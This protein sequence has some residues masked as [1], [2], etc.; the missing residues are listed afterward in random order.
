MCKH[1]KCFVPDFISV[2]IALNRRCK[3]LWL[4]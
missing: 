2:K 3:F 1:G 4:R